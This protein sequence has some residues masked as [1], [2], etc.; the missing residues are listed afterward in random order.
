VVSGLAFPWAVVTYRP[1]MALRQWLPELPLDP[2]LS[3]TVVCGLALPCVAVTYRPL[4][5]LRKLPL[6]LLLLMSFSNFAATRCRRQD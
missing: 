1:E 3:R 4:I 6:P 2:A 5:A